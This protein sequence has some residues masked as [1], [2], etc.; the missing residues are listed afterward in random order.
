MLG[1]TSA[2][3][4][5]NETYYG[6]STYGRMTGGGVTTTSPVTSGY[7]DLYDDSPT[8]NDSVYFFPTTGG[9]YFTGIKIATAGFTT[10]A[11]TSHTIIW[12]YYNGTQWNVLPG[13]WDGTAG[14]TQ[15]GSINWTKP[16]D[17][18]LYTYTYATTRH[19]KEWWVRARLSAMDT[20]TEGGQVYLS[21]N[22]VNIKPYTIY[23]TGPETITPASLYAT[24]EA[25]GWD[26][27]QFDTDKTYT[28][29]YG[30]I[31]R[32]ADV[33]F[34]VTGQHLNFGTP[35]HQAFYLM[36]SRPAK[37]VV[38]APTSVYQSKSAVYGSVFNFYVSNMDGSD[39]Y[40]GSAVEDAQF[41]NIFFSMHNKA[42]SETYGEI[43]RLGYMG[44]Y[45]TGGQNFNLIFDCTVIPWSAGDY[46]RVSFMN[47]QYIL[48][49]PA[50]TYKNVFFNK[51][52]TIDGSYTP[53]VEDGVFDGQ[54]STQRWYTM[55]LGAGNVLTYVGYLEVIDS[56]WPNGNK[57]VKDSH[58]SNITYTADFY[59]R[60]IYNNKFK[61]SVTDIDGIPIEN[62]TV[63]LK[64]SYGNSA[65]YT[66]VEGTYIST[67]FLIDATT[68]PVSDSSK[69]IVG[70]YYLALGEIFLVTAIPTGTTLTIEREKFNSRSYQYLSR[71]YP[72]EKVYLLEN[73]LSTGTNGNITEVKVTERSMFRKEQEY[74]EFDFSPFN[75]VIEKNGYKTYNSTFNISEK[76]DLKI[77][78]E[79]QPAWNYSN[80]LAWE[81]VNN[82]G[83]ASGAL[84][85]FGNMK[86]AQTLNENTNS[87]YIN[88]YP[89]EDV[90]WRI[91]DLLLLTKEGALY[92]L[93]KFMAGVI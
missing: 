8:I 5:F 91:T 2:T 54:S 78:L 92:I 9:P 32:S 64:D 63:T 70:R 1:L 62:V 90:S 68:I 7:Q 12:E 65:L 53:V 43:Y 72:S 60:T 75:L 20:I 44:A 46:E 11:S 38:N 6:L 86:I 81:F 80:Q 25:N 15:S 48:S 55:Q 69:F 10:I 84:D 45:G 83:I 4:T 79:E 31:L 51:I 19:Y 85:I 66:Q 24:S 50:A 40:F 22:Y 73:N 74:V 16:T 35:T 30:F 61:V 87:T 67:G 14:F 13:L 88:N 58:W 36:D 21:N 56:E 23:V 34:T 33:T 18:D 59:Y 57:Y 27:V 42:D 49:S 17:W 29:P 39:L 82:S 28:F 77:T 47:I 52:F 26:A 3:I 41:N 89:E 93:G 76:T 37:W 71:S